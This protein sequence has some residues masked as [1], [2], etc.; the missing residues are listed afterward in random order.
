MELLLSLMEKLP[1]WAVTIIVV[2]G[3]LR[4]ILKPVMELAKAIV[5]LT[6]SKADDELP[7][8]VEA[9]KAYKSVLF[10]LD[11]FASIKPI[12]K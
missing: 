4:I 9:S 12:K 5:Q 10:V 6:P 8:K 11:W 3:S 1:N 7:A 2:V